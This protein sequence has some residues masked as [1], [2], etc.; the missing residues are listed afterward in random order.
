MRRL[1]SATMI[2]LMSWI[3][4]LGGRAELTAA[5]SPAAGTW[6]VTLLRAGT[7]A[8]LWLLKIEEKDGKLEASL[9][10]ALPDFAGSTV[11][12]VHADDKAIR[13]TIRGKDGQRFGIAAYWPQDKPRP[14]KLRGSIDVGGQWLLAHLER[15]DL[16]TL[17]PEKAFVRGPAADA[18]E[19]A[20]D[21]EDLKEQEKAFKALIEK[22]RGE[23]AAYFATLTLIGLAEDAGTAEA[24]VRA[25]VEQAIKL[26][27]SHGPEMELQTALA[28]T[29]MLADSEKLAPVAVEYGNKVEKLLGPGGHPVAR[30]VATRSLL[31]ALHKTGQKEDARTVEERL[32]KAEESFVEAKPFPGRK[33]RS[34]RVALVEFF[35]GARCPPCVAADFA[36]DA[37]A[38]SHKP[39][40][41]V[42]L[43]YHLHI[44]GPDPLT[45]KDTEKRS[46]FYTVQGTPAIYLNGVEGPALGG[47][48]IHAQDRYDRLRKAV[49]AK[50][51]AESQAKVRVTAER[52][53]DKILIRAEV[54]EIAKP[55]DHLRLRF[56]LAEELVRFAA[57]N[58]QRFHHYVVR[59]MP[60]GP[61]G[62]PLKEKAGKHTA[63]V[64]LAELRKSLSDYITDFVKDQ[65]VPL[66]N[67]PADL[68]HLKV[69]AFI[70]NDTSKEVLQA[71][72][73]EVKE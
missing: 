39:S 46:E 9:P 35:T 70:Q 60:G 42:F 4:V 71:A 50:L 49:D 2:C 5:E 62:I 65:G 15:T 59:A 63:T 41:V 56:V 8:T 12:A 67:L 43:Q 73:V 57:P 10:A 18:Y 11:E 55:G 30:I 23:P 64:A 53:G 13:C 69:V 14:Q 36:F 51:E 24:E 40:D 3:C 16:K 32:Q 1:L 52:Q 58:G 6:K 38:R 48:L 20:H 54:S 61:E 28:V 33:A 34:D 72:Q 25:H 47:G 17:D 45:N 44:P 29:R 22:F 21:Q 7:E 37:L 31:T 66:D 19:K 68:K 26:V 27:Q